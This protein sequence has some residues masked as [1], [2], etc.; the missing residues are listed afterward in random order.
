MARKQRDQGGGGD[1]WMNTYS[2][3][4]T[5]LFAF[6]VLLFSMSSVEEEKWE[7]LV[8]AFTQRSDETTQ[9]ILVPEGQGHDMAQNQGEAPLPN[10]GD[11][12]DTTTTLP[13]EFSELFEYLKSYAEEHNMQ[14]SVEISKDANNMFVYI[15]FKDNVFFNPDS[16]TLRR[17]SYDILN[18]LG[19]GLK[20]VEEQILTI[21]INGHTAAIQG[22]T[23]YAVS[24]WRLSGDRA[25]NI[26]IFFE[27]QKGI[28]PTKMR[29]IGFGKNF[30]IADNATAEGRE[31]NRRVDMIIV[32]EEMAAASDD[33]IYQQML[34]LF[35][36][37]V[38]PAEGGLDA[39]LVPPAG[40]DA[41]SQEQTP[42]PPAGTEVP[43][44]GEAP[45]EGETP[46][47]A[48]TP[49]ETD[50]PPADDTIPPPSPSG[51]S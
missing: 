8:K 40:Q 12:I 42:E 6:F 38:F 29:P 5:L 25:A 33:A 34:G 22:V 26:A 14:D 17:D 24:D 45:V 49:P 50:T 1:S 35:D 27:E 32:N 36:P 37:S 15:R 3:M 21:N 10:S 18:F 41:G 16:S 31:K 9:I 46:P 20:N 51:Q 23:N 19:D 4:M 30:P 43:P 13:S 39:I 2:D 11:S 28:D 47:G 48:D 44:E 7:I